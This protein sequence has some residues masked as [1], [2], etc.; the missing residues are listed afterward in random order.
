MVCMMFTFPFSPSHHHHHHHCNHHLIISPPQLFT[1]LLFIS[2]YFSSRIIGK[3]EAAAIAAASAFP[4]GLHIGGGVT[5]E[6]AQQCNHAY[7]QYILNILI[8]V[9]IIDI[10]AGASHVIVSGFIFDQKEDN[11]A[12]NLN[13]LN[14]LIDTVGKQKVY[15]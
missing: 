5:P 10:Q 13:K 15:Y 2:S 3:S 4:G 8:L 6:N 9:F 11:S 7:I 14:Q 1:P 12:L